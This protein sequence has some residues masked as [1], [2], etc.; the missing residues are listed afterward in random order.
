MDDRTLREYYTKHFRDIVADAHPGSV[1]SSY[2]SVNGIPAP[3]NVYLIDTLMR[4]TFG[5]GGYLVSDCDA[6]YEIQNGHHWQPPGYAAPVNNIQ[7]HA[8]AMSAGED[9]NCNT[10][11]HDSSSYSTALPTA[12]SQAVP[13]LTD[14]FNVN[15]VD[16][17]LVRLFTA[18]MKL[19]EF[20]NGGTGVPW[21]DQARA[22]V[23]QGSWANNDT[24]NAVTETP[25]RLAMA[26]KAGDETIVLLKNSTTT[27][28]DGSVGKLLPL[29]V[30]TTGA[31]NVAVIGYFAN[32][33][34][35]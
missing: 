24:N 17:S 14:T 15:D 9:L 25:D 29:H 21:V 20:D 12:V 18:R 33:A 30:P 4:E 8:F 16:T 10:G 3:A 32:P 26:R 27:R 28:K 22:R 7:R 35:M 23:P 34:T 11:Y 1:M 31:F 19:G 6:I 13:T 5:F 2:N